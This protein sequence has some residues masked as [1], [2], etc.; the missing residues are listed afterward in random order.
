MTLRWNNRIHNRK[1]MRLILFLLLLFVSA[2][3]QAGE[4]TTLRV[5]AHPDKTRLVIEMTGTPEFQ[6]RMADNPK[7]LLITLPEKEWAIAGDVVL[8]A[9]FQGIQQEAVQ[10]GLTRI[11]LPVSG[12]FRIQTAFVLS[13][14]AT[15]QRLV[16]DLVPVGEALYKQELAVIHGPLITGQDNLVGT[17]IKSFDS[18][19]SGAAAVPQPAA[20]PYVREKPIIVL[21][22]GHGG[23]DPGA[24]SPGGIQEKQITLTMAKTVAAT[25][26][27]TG[28]YDAR[29]TRGDDRFIKL[30]DRVKIARNAD[31][32]F[33]ISIHADS[34]G[35]NTTRGASVY[36]LS[37][38]A[39]DAQTA[40]LAAR[41]NRADLIGGIDLNEEDDTVSAILIDLSMRETMNQSKIV[42]NTVIKN[43]RANRINTL[44]GP[45]RYAGFAVLKAP[46][47]PSILI[48]TG[49]VSNEGEAR[50]LLQKD[51]QTQIATAI[52]RTLDKYFYNQ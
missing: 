39:S 5:G 33:F 42:A 1:M 43:M 11:S 13:A 23:Q 2:P 46:D 19:D 7:R 34:V 3:L 22:P 4:I 30:Y 35:N 29:L 14:A 51:Y 50:R 26:N 49:F 20:K 25:L 6:A 45:H 24:I 12:P 44:K 18:G 9:P 28:R 31:A 38:T 47:V 15:S 32:D 8:A 48:E 16:I 10:N 17:L 21:D 36:T 27:A 37:D 41:E 52:R 40:K